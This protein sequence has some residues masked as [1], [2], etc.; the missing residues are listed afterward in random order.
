MF[1][2][3]CNVRPKNDVK[4]EIFLICLTMSSTKRFSTNGFIN[5]AIRWCTLLSFSIRPLLF[6]TSIGRF[7][8]IRNGPGTT[9]EFYDHNNRLKKAG[10]HA[11]YA[12]YI[13]HTFGD[14][15]KILMKRVELWTPFLQWSFRFIWVE[16]Q[17]RNNWVLSIILLVIPLDVCGMEW[18]YYISQNCAN[19]PT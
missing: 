1:Q 6:H 11:I 7:V 18:P 10:M 9:L 16:F 2:K 19:L 3:F 17:K 8:F 13:T 4:S 12:G 5:S 14:V 15:H